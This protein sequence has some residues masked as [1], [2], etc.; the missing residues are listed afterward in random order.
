MLSR[1]FCL[2]TLL[3]CAFT[4]FAQ[5][6]ICNPIGRGLVSPTYTEGRAFLTAELDG[7]V[8]EVQGIA[9]GLEGMFDLEGTS[10]AELRHGIYGTVGERLAT[11]NPVVQSLGSGLSFNAIANRFVLSDDQIDALNAGELYIQINTSLFPQGELR[12]QIIPQGYIYHYADIYPSGVTHAE[13]EGSLGRAMLYSDADSIYISGALSSTEG[14]V[15][16]IGRLFLKYG[17]AGQD[18]PSHGQLAMERDTATQMGLI[19]AKENAFRKDE[20][21]NI[22]FDGGGYYIELQDITLGRSVARGQILPPSKN[23]YL[24]DLRSYKTIPSNNSLASGK[25]LIVEGYNDTIRVTGSF[26]GLE[27]SVAQEVAGGIL[28]YTG[29]QMSSGSVQHILDSELT[30]GETQGIIRLPE[31]TTVYSDLAIQNLRKGQLYAQVHSQ[32]NFNGEIRGQ[33][34]P[35]GHNHMWAY[36]NYL[37]SNVRVIN[38]LKGYMDIVV[39]GEVMSMYG[40]A[41]GDMPD[42]VAFTLTINDAVAGTVGTKLYDVSTSNENNK[43]DI[44]SNENTIII[45]DT[46]KQRLFD[47]ALYF[48]I[49]GENERTARGQI[50]P[51]AQLLHYAPLSDRQLLTSVPSQANGLAIIEQYQDTEYNLSGSFAGMNTAPDTLAALYL[52]KYAFQ[53]FELD[54]LPLSLHADMKG[55]DFNTFSRRNDIPSFHLSSFS[56]NGHYI[57]VNSEEYPQGELRGQGLQICDGYYSTKLH[58]NNVLYDSKDEGEGNLLMLRFANEMRIE[59][60]FYNLNEKINRQN[61]GGMTVR[62]GSIYNNGEIEFILFPQVA[63]DSLSGVLLP[64]ENTLFSIDNEIE[65]LDAYSLYTVVQVSGQSIAGL[66]GQWLPIHLDSPPQPELL[67][68]AERDTFLIDGFENDELLI[69]YTDSDDVLTTAIH[70][71]SR[72]DFSPIQY[73]YNYGFSNSIGLRYEILD[74]LMQANSVLQGDTMRYY[75]RLIH[76]DGGDYSVSDLY[77]MELVRGLVTGAPDKYKAH[78]SANHVYPP[79]QSTGYGELQVNLI[80]DLVRIEGSLSDLMSPIIAD[81]I[82]IKLAYAGQSG[83]AVFLLN[84]M[85]SADSLSAQFLSADNTFTLSADQVAQLEGRQMYIEVKTRDFANGELRGQILPDADAYYYAN[86]LNSNV[87]PETYTPQGGAISIELHGTDMIVTGSFD[88][89]T[90]ELDTD[91][92]G[93][94]HIHKGLP[95]EVGERLFSLVPLISE[96]VSGIFNAASNTISITPEQLQELSRREWMADIHTLEN[97]LAA[98]GAITPI[99]KSVFR[100]DLAAVHHDDRLD[101]YARGIMQADVDT[102]NSLTLY[103][104]LHSLSEDY[105]DRLLLQLDPNN[106]LAARPVIWEQAGDKG[107]ILG[108]ANQFDLSEMQTADLMDRL[109]TIKLDEQDAIGGIKGAFLGQAQQYG[110]A[111]LSGYQL[112]PNGSGGDIHTFHTERRGDQLSLSGA[113]NVN[114][115]ITLAN[116]LAGAPVEDITAFSLEEE[117]GVW[118][119]S[120]QQARLTMDDH[121]DSLMRSRS[122]SIYSSQSRGQW[123]PLNRMQYLVYINGVALSSPLDTDAYALALVESN[124]DS[125][126]HISG[127]VIGLSDIQSAQIRSGLPGQNG[128]AVSTLSYEDAGAYSSIS[129]QA[130]NADNINPANG[131]SYI[132]LTSSQHPTGALRGTLRPLS[133]Y[134]YATSLNQLHSLPISEDLAFG[135]A[136]LDVAGNRAQYY[137]SFVWSGDILTDDAT[138]VGSGLV[139]D[140]VVT[141]QSLNMLTAENQAI[142]PVADNVFAADQQLKGDLANKQL[143]IEVLNPVGVS[144]LRGQ[145]KEIVNDIPNAENIGVATSVDTVF[146]NN[147]STELFTASWQEV[148]DNDVLMY[149]YQLSDNLDFT[150][151]LFERNI[152]SNLSANISY[153]EVLQAL[154]LNGNLVG[155]TV[156]LYQRVYVTDG[157][158]DAYINSARIEAVIQEIIL[159]TEEYR[160]YL[161]GLQQADPLLSLGQGQLTARLQGN[162]ISFEGSFEDMLSAYDAISGIYVYEG[163]AGQE[164]APLWSLNVSAEPNANSGMIAVT[165]NTMILTE[166]QIELLKNRQLYVSIP[167]QR[168]PNGEL[169]GQI[170]PLANEY[171]QIPITH[172]QTLGWHQ[173]IMEVGHLIVEEYDDEVVITGS[174]AAQNPMAYSLRSALPGQEGNPFLSLNHQSGVGQ[175]YDIFTAENNTYNLTAVLNTLI[176]QGALYLSNDNNDRPLRGQW[177]PESRALLMSHLSGLKTSPISNSFTNGHVMAR[178]GKSDDLTFSGTVQQVEGNNVQAYLVQ[179]T[180]G[181]EVTQLSSLVTINQPQNLTITADANKIDLSQEELQSLL[182]RELSLVIDTDSLLTYEARGQLLALAPLYSQAYMSGA[183]VLSSDHIAAHGTLEAEIHQNEIIMTGSLHAADEMLQNIELIQATAGLDGEKLLDLQWLQDDDSATLGALENTIPYDDALV[184]NMFINRVS[185]RA[186]IFSRPEGVAR[187]L[188]TAPVRAMF[189]APLSG[190][191]LSLPVSSIGSGMAQFLL[192]SNNELR[193]VAGA[194]QVPIASLRLRVGKAYPGMQDANAS[195]YTG[196]Q[197]QGTFGLAYNTNTATAITAADIDEM[198]RGAFYAQ[199]SRE[200]NGTFVDYLRGQLMPMHELSLGGTLNGLHILNAPNH[201]RMGKIA[202]SLVANDLHLLGSV[203]ADLSE[204]FMSNST[205]YTQVANDE[206]LTIAGN[207]IPY[208]KIRLTDAQLENLYD[209]KWAIAAVTN[210]NDTLSTQL[211]REINNFPANSFVESTSGEESITIE[212]NGDELLSLQWTMVVDPDPLKYILQISENADFTSLYAIQDFGTNT[213]YSIDY[214][215]LDSLLRTDFALETGES[216]ELH[217]RIVTTDG[218]LDSYG[219]PLALTL[220]RGEIV[221]ADDLLPNVQAMYLAPNVTLDS[222]TTLV[223]DSD[224]AQTI[225]LEIVD[226]SGRRVH[227]Q[228]V[229]LLSGSN[230]IPIQMSKIAQGHYKLI[231]KDELR[232]Q[233]LLHWIIAQ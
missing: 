31:N 202:A 194:R 81:S 19:R 90:N 197:P 60:R 76:S 37:Q 198:R 42:S 200:N 223:L 134:H 49:L 70:I 211:I 220:I 227:S 185:I 17:Y 188:V 147:N 100:A 138:Q 165:D 145:W 3:F 40:T 52:G 163:Y 25:L 33:L 99:V 26:E 155:D 136:N 204:S 44:A 168:Y 109:V 115:D 21:D 75:Y 160:V 226:M 102:T 126:S 221:H 35:Q 166:D 18:G 228:R 133:N 151:I 32:D 164:G 158:E 101:S 107:S 66:R 5:Q 45:D 217:F 209:N 50:L 56:K 46:A 191:G 10:A 119:L 29:D 130:I 113:M 192:H 34:L 161:S 57:K 231:V 178:L 87:N 187:G 123:M 27:S 65:L 103:G 117:N 233:S 48:N 72:P 224:I 173:H 156:A 73:A 8:L 152:K 62:R 154:A 112:L 125:T 183:Q 77:A 128:S 9:F 105:N 53:G 172:S 182:Q 6:Y 127:A 215:T 80:G 88:N 84:P 232:N 222:Y 93:G 43:L 196:F 114:G 205:L 176:D 85:L 12:A 22:Y 174:I 190:S 91:Q 20:L 108:A 92:E 230:R 74:S 144:L 189:M 148:T 170:L 219:T 169:R 150:N 193:I 210:D 206:D 38:D 15:D 16:S 140:P 212:G 184:G 13:P 7:D 116:A 98:R 181:S 216:V 2:T 63:A 23:V 142:W 213:S 162:T 24:S 11:M 177:I 104:S 225:N 135:K 208:Q 118:R 51:N 149:V 218:A 120:P 175:A 41:Q 4:A 146:V 122:L 83:A 14:P 129:L 121:I 30:N 96:G 131:R 95:G 201:D 47:R 61:Q 64:E 69:D 207:T 179:G 195:A 167:S 1:I 39:S 214:H 106:I 229:D 171:H 28:V 78:L 54:E 139:Y 180:T 110:Y 58:A 89:L 132:S 67:T 199:V 141:Y 71:S 94:V 157:S 36:M 68:P 143:N 97:T 79:E 82:Q 111:A 55:A 124:W 159:P 203:D 153:Q 86:L 186:N 59:G 137:G